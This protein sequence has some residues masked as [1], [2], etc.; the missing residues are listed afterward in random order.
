MKKKFLLPAILAILMCIGLSGCTQIS[1]LFLSDEDKIIGSWYNDGTWLEVPADITFST[2]G[3]LKINLQ[4]G[5]IGFF[6]EGTWEM[7]DGI[8]S[9]ETEDLVPLTN[10]RYLFTDDN[11]KLTLTEKDTNDSFILTKK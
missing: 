7:K 1:N 6:S 2:N 8:L 10:F 5:T 3:T 9:M 4:M 11:T